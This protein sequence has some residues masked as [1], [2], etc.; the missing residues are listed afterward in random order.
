VYVLS[1]GDYSTVLAGL[2]IIDD[3]TDLVKSKP[4]VS[5]GYNVPIYAQGDFIYYPTADNKIAV[6]NAKTQTSSSANFITDG[7]VITTPYAISGDVLTGEIFVADAKDY[8]SNG[9]VT[10]FDKTGKKEYSI[11][12]GISPGKIALINK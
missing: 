4:T 2:T 3:K 7:T 9:T 5:L 12:T 6:Y 1:L 10:A 11:V 8:S